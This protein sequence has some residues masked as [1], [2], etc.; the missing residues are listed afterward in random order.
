[1][2]DETRKWIEFADENLASAKILLE[3][4]LFNACLQNIQKSVEK[5]LK[6]LLVEKGHK[7][8]KTHSI[9]ELVQ[10]LA[11]LQLDMEIA[12]ED[13]DLLDAIYLPTKY[14]LGGAL[15]AF[16]PDIPLCR[17]CLDIGEKIA[18]ISHKIAQG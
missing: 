17:R 15:P 13:C 6:A 18:A 12:D 16:E 9:N 4:N 2:R 14:P 11:D 1:M 10:L 3:Q 7:V 8:R 5:Y